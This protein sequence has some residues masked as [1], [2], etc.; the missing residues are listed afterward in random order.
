MA[1]TIDRFTKG[2]FEDVAKVFKHVINH[3]E[4]IPAHHAYTVQQAEFTRLALATGMANLYAL[5]NPRFDRTKFLLA[6][7]AAK[8]GDVTATVNRA[9]TDDPARK[10]ATK[11]GA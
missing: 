4:A 3:I 2:H 7:G 11:E 5:R 10:G 8:R 9:A 1:K 6:C